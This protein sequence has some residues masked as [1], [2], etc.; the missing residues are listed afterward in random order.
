MCN[1]E[2]NPVNVCKNQS[3]VT[4]S[5]NIGI[6][7]SVSQMRKL[8]L[9]GSICSHTASANLRPIYSPIN[10]FLAT[11]CFSQPQ[12]NALGNKKGCHTSWVS[13][14]TKFPLSSSFLR[15]NSHSTKNLHSPGKI[16][17][18]TLM[19]QMTFLEFN[20]VINYQEIFKVSKPNRDLFPNSTRGGNFAEVFCGIKH[21]QGEGNKK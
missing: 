21:W 5:N 13:S 1:G 18:S 16:H 14:V 2:Q 6:F 12:F 15:I 19:Y 7:I 11:L 9:R 17:C 3:Q 4:E 20:L 10:Y 8:I